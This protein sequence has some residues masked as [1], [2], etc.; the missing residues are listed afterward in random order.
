MCQDSENI[1]LS[2]RTEVR[3]LRRFFPAADCVKTAF[4][5]RVASARTVVELTRLNTQP[6]ALSPV[7]GLLLSFHTLWRSKWHKRKRQAFGHCGQSLV[8]G[9]ELILTCDGC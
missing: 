4:M 9:R 3:D 7:E 6:F 8:W 2:S 1:A 5:L